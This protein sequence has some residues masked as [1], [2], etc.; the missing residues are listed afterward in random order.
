MLTHSGIKFDTK[1]G[2]GVLIFLPNNNCAGVYPLAASFVAGYACMPNQG[3]W[4]FFN[5]HFAVLTALSASP[6][7]CGYFGLLVMCVN[8]NSFENCLNSAQAYCGP[9]SENT[10]SGL[11][12]DAKNCLSFS[13]TVFA[14]VCCSTATS[15]YLE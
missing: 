12:W 10:I 11:P 4:D 1:H 9:L 6:L 13:I 5:I 3:S 15:K 7:L 2:T 14:V 8:Q